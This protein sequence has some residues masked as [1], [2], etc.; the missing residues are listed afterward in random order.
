M[1]GPSS[2]PAGQGGWVRVRDLTGMPTLVN[3][4]A[5]W[6]RAC[7]AEQLP[8]LERLASKTR[9]R[10]R[11]LGV[12]ILDQRSDLLKEVRRYRLTYPS[13]DDPNASLSHGL[14]VTGIPA[15][16]LISPAGKVVTLYTG[17][18]EDA[19]LDKLVRRLGV[20]T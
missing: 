11:V 2:C 20:R 7:T 8:A 13:L 6:C 5:S 10:L 3:I 14:A 19:A 18:L 9:R 16:L 17:I 15:T 1:T 12:A 4:W